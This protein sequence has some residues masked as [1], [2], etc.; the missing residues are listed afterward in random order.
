MCRQAR[1]TRRREKPSGTHGS[2]ATRP[3]ERRREEMPGKFDK[4]LLAS[5]RGPAHLCGSR[6]KTRIN[7][8]L[9]ARQLLLFDATLMN[10]CSQNLL[11]NF[12]DIFKHISEASQ[13]G[14]AVHII[15]KGIAWGNDGFFT[16]FMF[17]M[18]SP[19]WLPARPIETR[20]SAG[21]K[22]Q[23]L[24]KFTLPWEKCFQSNRRFRCV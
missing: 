17:V 15:S 21:D 18:S 1:Q 8:S 19:R 13:E 5:S 9:R 23:K 2:T 4:I 10:S 6:M 16:A 3:P 22:M 14:A 12:Q 11:Y 20:Q 24:I 7:T